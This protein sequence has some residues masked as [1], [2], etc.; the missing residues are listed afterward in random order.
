MK[1]KLLLSILIILA[2]LLTSIACFANNTNLGEELKDSGNK[3]EHTIQNAGE[4]IKNIASDI[5]NGIQN[6]ASDIGRGVENVF[7]TGNTD[8]SHTATNGYTA[9]RTSTAGATT[10]MGGMSRTTW[11]WLIMGIVGIVIIALTWY[12]VTQN[13]DSRK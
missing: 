2:I 5:G 9:T 1:N 6:A 12:Y 10:G 13:N 8:G 7:H 3:S 4:G 11:V